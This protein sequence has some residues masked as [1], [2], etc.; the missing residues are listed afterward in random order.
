MNS[1]FSGDRMLGVAGISAVEGQVT[2]QRGMELMDLDISRVNVTLNG[3]SILFLPN[4]CVVC[5][6]SQLEWMQEG[7]FVI[8]T[9][10]ACNLLDSLCL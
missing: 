4:L 2:N 10:V 3:A 7:R 5:K 8:S 6:Q 1:I 9:D